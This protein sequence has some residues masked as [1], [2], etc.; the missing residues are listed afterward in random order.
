MHAGQRVKGEDFKKVFSGA[1]ISFAPTL[2]GTVYGMSFDSMPELRWASGT[3]HPRLDEGGMRQF[4]RDFQAARPAVAGT[5]LKDAPR[6]VCAYIAA[7]TT[8]T[9]RWGEVM[10]VISSRS[11]SQAL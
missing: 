2:V 6:T 3:L 4:V 8:H 7:Q 1:A 5:C 9:G 11:P 10:R